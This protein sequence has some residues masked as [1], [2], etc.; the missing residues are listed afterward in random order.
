MLSY[1]TKRFLFLI[2]CF[3]FSII[4]A[5]S[6]YNFKRLTT[7]EGLPSNSVQKV[8]QG[9]DGYIWF[10]TREG[11]YQYDGENIIP[12]KSNFSNPELLTNNNICSVSEDNF[13]RLWIGTN[14][15]LNILHIK[16][17][18]IT[19]VD[20]V[21]LNNNTINGILHTKENR[22]F[23]AAENGLYE[24]YYDKD[25]LVLYDGKRTKGV[26]S[27]WAIKSLIEDSYGQIWIGTWNGGLY[28]YDTV[29][30]V[31]YSY[32]KLHDSNVAHTIFE[33]S[34]KR[35][36]V[37]TWGGGL[38]MLNNAYDVKNVTWK[39]YMA[40]NSDQSLPSNIIY[41]ISEDINSRKI[42]VGTRLGLSILEDEAE[43]VFSN[44]Y[45]SD[46]E[47]TISSNEVN[48]IVCD[49][50][51]VMW[52]GLLRGGI[53]IVNTKKPL[54]TSFPFD[55]LKIDL[56]T[57]SIACLYV[58]E[59]CMWL[60]VSGYGLVLYSLNEDRYYFPHNLPNFNNSEV[61]SV[62]SICK[63]KYDGQVWFGTYNNG[64]YVYDENLKG[65]NKIKYYYTE[66]NSWMSGH[67]FFD[68]YEDSN[69][70][71]W[72]GSNRGF[73]MVSPNFEYVRF[74][75]I[76]VDGVQLNGVIVNDIIE[77]EKNEF[78]VATSNSG[79]FK[80]TGN[81]FE[82]DNYHIE[83]YS[84]KKKNLNNNNFATLFKDEKNNIWAGSEGGGLSIF[85]RKK[86]QFIPLHNEWQ[87][88]GDAVY[89][90]TC[91][92]NGNLWLATNQG[93]VK[94]RFEDD[95]KVKINTYST[96][97]GLL[98][99]NFTKKAFFKKD[100][101]TIFLGGNYGLN[102]FN[103]YSFEEQDNVF[104]P[105][106]I[107]DIKVHNSSLNA[108]SK[109]ERDKFTSYVPQY[110]EHLTLDYRNNN[111]TIEFTT[112]G[113]DVISHF[114]YSYMLEGFD[115][116][117]N[118]TKFNRQFAY[119]NNLKPG[120]Y[121]FLLKSTN[122]N[123]VWTDEVLS[124]NIK[125]LPPPW[126]TWWAY[127]V[128]IVGFMLILFFVYHTF[129]TRIR[130]KNQLQLREVEKSKSE[131]M[132]HAKLQFFTNI[133]HEFYT[134]LT[135]ISA[136]IDDLKREAPQFQESHYEVV[137]SNVNRL[138]RL[139]Q[140]ILEFRKAESGNLKLVVSKGDLASFVAN[141]VDSFRPLIKKKNFNFIVDINP[142]PFVGYFD[143]D[144]LDKILYNL[145]SNAS[146]YNKTNGNITV[147][148]YKDDKLKSAVI[149]VKDDG[150]GFS[151]SA[152]ENLFQRFY[153]GDYRK[154]KTLGTGIGLSLTKDLV[155]LHGG[156]IVVES[157]KGFG[158]EFIV[159]IPYLKEGYNENDIDDEVY[160]ET[161]VLDTFKDEKIE[162]A[163]IKDVSVDGEIATLLLVEDNEDLLNL[164]KNLLKS[165]YKII[166]ADNGQDALEIIK[167]SDIDLI[168]SDIMMPIMDGVELCRIIK[169]NFDY[170]HI[171]LLLLTAKTG[172]TDRI[173]AYDSGADAYLTKPFN[174]SLLQSRIKNLLKS[175]REKYDNFQKQLLFEVQDFEY[176]TLDEEFL[177]KA[178]ECINNNIGNPD[179]DQTHFAD[180]M[181]V[182]R[183]TLF[184]KMKSLTG[185]TYVSFIKNVRLKAA[186]KMMQEKENIRI[187][188]L[189][190]AVG[191]NDPRYFSSCFKKEFGLTPI[192]FYEKSS[193]NKSEIIDDIDK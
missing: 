50:Q 193:N 42:W 141:S 113:F 65:I 134:P 189:A 91:D 30:E 188:E 102:S 119:Y 15:G 27:T 142:T 131:E 2:F 117:W 71:R 120:S 185:M 153:E 44:Y 130:L 11:L 72:I 97:D 92:E 104:P 68:I 5:N 64:I 87:L 98:N 47:L 17:G 171:P 143:P 166:T 96:S 180:D 184:R 38:L 133:T 52:L 18:V 63:M 152:L 148:L 107:T 176:T 62:F 76:A 162:F 90:I 34:K 105:L 88:P 167:N 123:G 111:F 56:K 39:T 150:V 33:D 58:D 9:K 114:A 54:F 190:Y 112:L 93:L 78:W 61:P 154:F 75:E 89:N 183:S 31:F 108:V 155:T 109:E 121:T 139:L 4:N 46:S 53:N 151:K 116:Q 24:Y 73:T 178:V 1:Y 60:G 175:R 125:I 86:N 126:L 77:G 127:V 163:N 10:A 110:T 164:M 149:S 132:N 83:N 160:E 165:E 99:N 13:Q 169:S 6:H 147:K 135:I 8:Y 168:V 12:Y 66:E 55:E 81:G 22:T 7:F 136:S 181:G 48:S 144:K 95:K 23:L 140:Q 51:G 174:L 45:P 3:S 187:S 14:K 82:K 118:F 128:Y 191:F 21:N 192:E 177:N 179:Y 173:N 101:G 41:A 79:I 158:A 145:L 161:A 159:K 40:N 70:N 32:P 122:A 19:K 16:T 170:S 129:L 37:G 156:T 25:S 29:T 172:E 186:C 36:W 100:D 182:S 67:Q 124:L 146:K 137:N 103:S 49:S 94:L 85:D 59:D 35:I 138:I 157:E 28:R 74:D 43:G 20:N 69:F 26:I 115:N 80:V 84:L 57:N 106:V